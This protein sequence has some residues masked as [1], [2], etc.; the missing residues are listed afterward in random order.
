MHHDANDFTDYFLCSLPD[1]QDIYLPHIKFELLPAKRF[2][3][4]ET[5]ARNIYDARKGKQYGDVTLS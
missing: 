1:N 4:I 2:G 3:E 5:A